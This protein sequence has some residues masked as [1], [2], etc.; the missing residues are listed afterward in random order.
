MQTPEDPPRITRR[1]LL[2]ALPALLLAGCAKA[3]SGGITSP[4][5]GPQL[6]IS[7]TVAGSINAAYYYFVL[8]NVNM[9]P[10]ANNSGATGP[11]PVVAPPFV[12]GFAAGAFTNYVEYNQSVPG[13]TGFGF[14][15]IDP[16]LRQS[17][18]IGS[19]GYLVS[20]L[21]SGNTLSFQL[22]LGFLATSAVTADQIQTLQI[23]FITTNVTPVTTNGGS[24]NV[25]KYFDSLYTPDQ[26]AS[27]FVNVIVR[28]AAGGQVMQVNYTNTNI[29]AAGDV[30]QVVNGVP[31]IVSGVQSDGAGGTVT[32][33]DLDITDFTIR[34]NLQ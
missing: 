18:Y 4:T 27:N 23:N 24:A 15:T 26:S 30:A 29:E 7:M 3:P 34:L 14:Y 1:S 20:S 31:V 11:V 10:N 21:V 5:S 8:F 33:A 12:N 32:I 19:S 17:N 2:L 6:L 28:T 13:G 9:T 16:A 25:N 22:P